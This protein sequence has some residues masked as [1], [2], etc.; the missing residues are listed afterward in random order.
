MVSRFFDYNCLITYLGE[1]NQKALGKA[2]IKVLGGGPKFIPRIKDDITVSEYNEYKLLKIEFIYYIKEGILSES[3]K[4]KCLQ[5]LKND[6]DTAIT[7]E[8]KNQKVIF[9]FEE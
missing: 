7:A 3:E 4:T 1:L 8:L 5:D 6:I 2:L 9:N